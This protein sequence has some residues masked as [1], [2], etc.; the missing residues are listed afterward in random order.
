MSS[1][2]ILPAR[3]S[4]VRKDNS[5][6]TAMKLCLDD[7]HLFGGPAAFENTL[8]VGRPNVGNRDRLFQRI[9]DLLDRRWLTNNGPY[10]LELERRIANLVG[11]KHCIATSN[12][13][14]A[15]EITIKAAELSGEVIVPSFTFVATAHALRWLGITPIFCDISPPSPNLDPRAVERAITPS[16]TGIVGVHVWGKPCDVDA[17]DTIARRHHLKLIFDAAHAFG[18]TYHGRTIGQFGDAEVF[19]FHAT[20]FLN[21]FEGGAIVT[22]D[23]ALAAQAR[24]MR[25]FGFAGYDDVVSVGT[26]GKMSEVCAAMG[27][28]SLESMDEFIEVNEENYQHYR[29]EL[30]GVRGIRLSPYDERERNNYHYVV[31]E[32]DESATGISRDLLQR[33]LWA[34]NV[35]ARRYFYPGCHHVEPYRSDPRYAGV[36]LPNTDRL[37]A[38]VLSLPTGTTVTKTMITKICEIMR[39]V[40]EHSADV[41]ERVRARPETKRSFRD[42]VE[43][44]AHGR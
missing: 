18:C 4:V 7:L 36:C 44:A 19:S 33:I 30:D 40:T 37:A 21:S 42:V 15:L 27:L 1:S 6:M 22:N 25:N 20:K 41:N 29:R 26:N 17:L 43:M 12:A 14:V 28:T 32:V 3:D 13:T 11:V 5:R 16:T 35:R 8:H 2:V 10:V 34:E 38:R 24:L 31:V 23:D 39:L 9:D